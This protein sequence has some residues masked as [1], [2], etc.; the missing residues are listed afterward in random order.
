MLDLRT[1]GVMQTYPDIDNFRLPAPSCISPCGSWVLGG[2]DCGVGICWNTDTG[3]KVHIFR[4]LSSD[5]QISA[6]AFHPHEHALVLGSVEPNSQVRFKPRHG[7]LNFVKYNISLTG[8][9]LYL[10]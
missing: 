2:S 5:K 3:E 9:G 1:G 8:R 6:I 7:V 10:R 4:E